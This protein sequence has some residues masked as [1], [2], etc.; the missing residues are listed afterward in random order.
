VGTVGC[1]EKPLQDTYMR[2]KSFIDFICV[3]NRRWVREDVLSCSNF[4][5]VG[6]FPEL[7]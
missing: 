2:F 3:G 5:W 6:P 4:M 1:G 7:R